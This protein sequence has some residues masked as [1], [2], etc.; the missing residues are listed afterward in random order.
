MKPG[1]LVSLDRTVGLV[2]GLHAFVRM[3]WHQVEPGPFKDNWHIGAVCEHLEAVHRG[4]IRRLVINIPP[5]C[6]KSLTTCVF[7]PVWSW[8]QDPKL[9]WIFTSYD[10]RL[11]GKRDGGRCLQLVQSSWFRQRW[12]HLFTVPA[13]EAAAGDFATSAGGFRYGTSFEGGITGRHA[14]RVVIDDP[15][16]PGNLTK[17]ALDNCEDLWKTTLRSRI[18]PEDEGGAAVLIMQRLHERD[19]AGIFEKEGGWDFLR[20]P[21]RFESSRPCSTSIGFKDPRE[22]DGELLFPSRFSDTEVSARA[23]E[24]GPI[25]AAAQEQQR[26]T[27]E[28]GAIFQ[29]AWFKRYAAAP[30]RFEMLLQSWDMAF[31]GEKDSDFVCGQVWGVLGGEYYLL[32]RIHE[33]LDFPGTVAAVEAMCRKWPRAGVKLVEA[34]ANGPAVVSHLKKKISGFV[35]IEPEGGKIARANGVAPYYEAGNVL[36][37]LPEHAPWIDDHEAELLAFPKGAHDDSVDASTQALAWVVM[38]ASQLA[39]AMSAIDKDPSRLAA[40]GLT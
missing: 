31:K 20:L 40:L 6:M 33:R 34:K 16:K 2:D 13:K 36:H 28:G 29:R 15:I 25:G 18:L 7:W 14:H 5:G 8:I 26:P 23:R 21:M 17:V 38:R 9:R 10:G 39:A 3:A 12:G 11:T 24:M 1:A 22:D 27:P 4:E 19:L 37:P 35:E 32:D 30:A